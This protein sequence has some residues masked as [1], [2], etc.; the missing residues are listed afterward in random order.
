MA[1]KRRLGWISRATERSC[2]ATKS[3]HCR[4][5]P[6]CSRQP[7]P[8]SKFTA[9]RPA[10]VITHVLPLVSMIATLLQAVTIESSGDGIDVGVFLKANRPTRW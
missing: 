7:S 2:F 10:A 4:K 9:I 8:G 1:T 5:V 3:H 6:S